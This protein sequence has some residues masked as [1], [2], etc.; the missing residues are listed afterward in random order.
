MA[1]THADLERL[2]QAIASQQLEVQMDGRRVRY[3]DM[4]ELLTARQHVAQQ[5]AA[6]SGSGSTRRF[7]FTTLRGD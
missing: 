2:D 7:T 4:S 6:A 1:L 5:I 3:R